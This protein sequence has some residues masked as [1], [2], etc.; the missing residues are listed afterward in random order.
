LGFWGLATKQEEVRILEEAQ[1]ELGAL[2]AR[3]GE[4]LEF[5]GGAQESSKVFRQY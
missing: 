2:A 3:G 5:Y 1:Q 4:P